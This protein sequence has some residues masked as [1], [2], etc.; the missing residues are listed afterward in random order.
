MCDFDS[1]IAEAVTEITAEAMAQGATLP[2]D[3]EAAA[4]EH[5]S[6]VLTQNGRVHDHDQL[7][8]RLPP[9]GWRTVWPAADLALCLLTT[10]AACW[11]FGRATSPVSDPLPGALWA[12]AGM[13]V[14]AG[15]AFGIAWILTPAEG[16]WRRPLVGP[17][18]ATL[19]LIGLVTVGAGG[20]LTLTEFG[21]PAA[22]AS[23]GVSILLWVALFGKP[24]RS[25]LLV[26][27]DPQAVRRDKEQLDISC[28]QA[29]DSLRNAL[30][31]KLRTEVDTAKAQLYSTTLAVARTESLERVWDSVSTYVDTPA[32]DRVRAAIGGMR[33]GSI[34]LS[35]PRGVGKSALLKAL[36]GDSETRNV[37]VEA[38]VF[39]DKRD[40]MLHLFAAACKVVIDGDGPRSMRRLAR[41]HLRQITHLQTRTREGGLT[42]PWLGLSHKGGGSWTRQPLTHPEVVSELKRF[43]EQVAMA[44]RGKSVMIGIDELDRIQPAEDAEKFLNEIK[45]IFDVQG[46]LFILTVSDEALREADL[47]PVGARG[48]FDSAIDEVVRCEPLDQQLAARLLEPRVV[49]VPLPFVGLFNALAGGIPRDLVRTA[50]AGIIVTADS[51]RANQSLHMTTQR[52]VRRELERTVGSA[53]QR[54]PTVLAALLSHDREISEEDLIIDDESTIGTMLLFLATVIHVFQDSTISAKLRAP[55]AETVLTDLARARAGIGV[56]NHLARAELARIR[57]AWESLPFT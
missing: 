38:P 35:G 24:V 4:S 53:D 36:C 52:L 21:W 50:R 12:L 23:V 28:E 17:S 39:Y 46:C 15:L 48:V 25:W 44:E 9:R 3:F 54:V 7:A 56:A 42:L 5:F 2:R 20:Y 11:L 32:A 30:R 33:D 37:V 1:V 18:D 45:A 22:L 10:L 49:G 19:A 47:A 6:V 26:W 40:F 41:L 31:E 27:I 51:D 55:E 29:R 57:A 13:V 16:D 8:A 43:L 34:A 14:G